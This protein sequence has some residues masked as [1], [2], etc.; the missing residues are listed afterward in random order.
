MSLIYIYYLCKKNNI[1]DDKFINISLL[2]NVM[3]KDLDKYYE[4]IYSY[5][6]SKLEN[7][8]DIHAE[9]EYLF[10]LLNSKDNPLYSIKYQRK[11]KAMQT[12]T[13]MSVGDV[14]KIDNIY[15]IVNGDGFDQLI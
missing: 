7:E 1:T 8:I 5:S 6:F 14:I 13:C 9:L 15:Y 4:C 2:G 12:H 10:K 11:I 3:K